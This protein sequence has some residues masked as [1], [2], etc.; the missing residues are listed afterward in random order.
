MN[1]RKP[2][3]LNSTD[4][5]NPDFQAM[6]VSIDWK[7]VE[8]SVNNLQARIARAAQKE[9]W[10]E[11]EKLVRL[12]T[13]SYYAKLLAVRQVTTN[14]GRRTPGVDGSVWKSP[15][16]KM[17][18]ALNLDTHN[19]Q[20]SP[21]LR[22][23][24]PKKNGK[25]RPLSIPTMRDRAMQALFA[26]A[27]APVEYTTGDPSSFGFRKFRNTKDA[28]QQ[29][30]CCLSK[31]SSAK[32]ILEADIK[33]CFDMISHEWLLAHIPMNRNILKQFLKAGF[34][35]N[36][37][38]FPSTSGTPQGGVLSPILANMTLNG[39]ENILGKRYYSNRKGII[40]KK[41]NPHKVNLIRYADDIIITANTKEIA[42]E[43][44]Q[45]IMEFLHER[46][47]QLSV[48]K[49]KITHIYDGF[50]FLGW[51]FR[52]FKE[53]LLI[54]PSKESIKSIT[55]KIHAILRKGRTWTQDAIIE[56]IN[57]IIRGWSNYHRHICAS[58]IFGKLDH[59]IWN[60]LYAWVKRRHPNEPKQVTVNKYWHRKGSRNWVF[61]SDKH[62][63]LSLSKTKIWRYHM[64]KRDMNPFLNTDYFE[65][66][67]NGMSR[68]KS[69]ISA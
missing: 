67:K 65:K 47:L 17:Q 25:L 1:V 7:Q 51:E 63:L 58:K 5:T 62:E 57:P 42:E 48:E 56:C 38:M 61:S 19:Y 39:L 66:R 59:V 26:L 54:R 27:L 23:Y 41:Y 16:D 60:M 30:F 24:I 50:T 3:M 10:K 32:W 40:T 31:R 18:A 52:K 28:C 35:E 11:V 33:S 9:K 4:L 15:A 6:W 29:A 53:K 45:I 37:R 64:V 12:L 44:K 8:K 14:K 21:L 43:I 49:T 2:E 55:D 22:T 20:A 68:S 36:S 69:H 46:G 13:Q 34:L